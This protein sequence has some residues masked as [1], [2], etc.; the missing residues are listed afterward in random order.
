MWCFA[1]GIPQRREVARLCAVRVL[2]SLH[3][4]LLTH[5]CFCSPLHLSR[6]LAFFN[7]VLPTFM[8]HLYLTF[9]RVRISFLWAVDAI[10][11]AQFPIR[12]LVPTGPPVARCYQRLFDFY[13][14]VVYTVHCPL[15]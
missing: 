6:A 1:G 12:L 5:F 8:C 13:L 10:V 4:G 14:Q 15:C 11:A 3:L 9:S 2:G 7:A